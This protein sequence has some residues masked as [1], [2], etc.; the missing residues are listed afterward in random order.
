MTNQYLA[1]TIIA[2]FS[3]LCGVILVPLAASFGRKVGF[4]DKPRPGEVQKRPIP[5]SGGYGIFIAFFLG[6]AL[7]FFLLQRF[8]EE[9]Q[10][11]LGLFLGAL[12]ILPLAI[13]D[14]MRR[15]GPWPQLAWQLAIAAVPVAFGIVID[16]MSNPFGGQI[17]F[18][19]YF[20]IPF[21]LL[22]IVG[23]INTMNFVDTMDGLAAGIATIAGFILFMVSMGLGQVTIASL[24]LILASAAGAFLIFNFHPAKVF[25]GTSGSVFLGYILAMVAII[26]GAKIATAGLVL[27]I[28]IL[29]VLSVVVSRVSRRRSPFKGGDSAHLPHRLLATGMTE[30]Q[31]AFLLYAL[32]AVFG[33]LS[34]QLVRVE[35]F[36]AFAVMFLVLGGAAYYVYRRQASF[37]KSESLE[38]VAGP[39]MQH[40]QEKPRQS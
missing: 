30:R 26:G 5:R 11:L 38:P 9:N 18:P 14:D 1:L 27:G 20:A 22:W 2:L 21:T 40:E 7:S 36:W 23:M 25:M 29:D 16:S 17:L 31:I 34:L 3:F 19:A 28:P 37:R 13:M 39:G 10:R 33:G 12:L 32:C 24:P 6:L 4:V 15:L 35:K 8:P